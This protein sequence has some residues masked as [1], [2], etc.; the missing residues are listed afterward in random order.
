ML[1]DDS[2]LY[3]AEATLLAGLLCAV[4]LMFLV[5]SLKR[6]AGLDL[7]VLVAVAFA[8]RFVV[9]IAQGLLGD[10]G[11]TLRLTD[12][13]VSLAEANILASTPITDKLWS[14]SIPGDFHLTFFGA[15]TWLMGGPGGT[16]L[17]V[18]QGTLA[19]GGIALLAAAAARLAGR[20]A[21]LAAGWFLAIEPTCVLFTTILH[22]ESFVFLGEGLFALGAAAC[23]QRR[24]LRF[25]PAAIAGIALVVLVRPYAGWFLAAAG[26]FLLAHI[27]VT[28]YG[29]DR[30]RLPV[31]AAAIVLAL[32]GA[33]YAGASGNPLK[34][35]DE[36][37]TT[38]PV[39]ND[40]LQLEPVD[41]TTVGGVA[42]GLPGRIADFLF[43]PFPW[44]A[45]N[46]SQRLGVIGTLI[47][48]TLY[49]LLGYALAAGGR[50]AIA[51]AVP[52]LWMAAFLTL[53]YAVTTANAGA[54]Y[55]H[56]I[57]LLLA[58]AAAV[59]TLM[60]DRVPAPRAVLRAVRRERAAPA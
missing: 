4:A 55:R 60:A 49:A 53:C 42:E 19:V 39:E 46:L 8:A 35:L 34:Q 38:E 32:L 48:Y 29:P 14:D 24:D 11:E 15:Q 58:L 28:G 26:T 31:V 57:H 21:G 9:V 36:L 16:P 13:P 22:K 37:Q 44:Q 52:F 59:A 6:R 7:G 50:P 54:G 25:A 30:R 12:D 5:R 23:W 41:F 18:V 56:R 47:A 3:E 1:A 20:R 43:R 27:L 51:R 45:E 10:V 40:N 2:R 33:G 17:R